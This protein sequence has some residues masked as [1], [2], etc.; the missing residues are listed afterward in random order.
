MASNIGVSSQQLP[1]ASMIIMI[2]D[3]PSI[4]QWVL[5]S[6]TKCKFKE[7]TYFYNLQENINHLGSENATD[8][9]NEKKM[10]NILGF[11]YNH[12]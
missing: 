5:K 4:T 9:L 12:L 6:E 1:L 10:N 3:I 2:R 8:L 11:S 7:S